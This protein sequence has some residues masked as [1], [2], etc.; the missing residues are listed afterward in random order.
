MATRAAAARP[1]QLRT[2]AWTGLDRTGKRVTGNVRS[3]D[4]DFVRAQLRAR[5]I[6]RVRVRKRSALLE[7]RRRIGP[8]DVAYF[9]RQMAT[10]LSSGVP[11]VTAFDIVGRGHENPAMMRLIMTL[12]ADVEGGSSLAEALAKHPAH[13]NELYVNL[14]GAGE[15][16]G[17]LDGLLARLATFLEKTEAIKRK[18]RSAL[19][20]PA[21]VVA[22]GIIVTAI[23]L[24][25]VIPVFEDLFVSF[26]ANLP[27]LTRAVMRLSEFTQQW[28]WLMGLVAIGAG[29]G[30]WQGY[31]R[32]VRFQH[33]VDR[34]SLRI[35]IIGEVLRKATVARFARTLSTMFAA[36]VP[37]VDA[38]ES[39]A[40]ASGNVVYREGILRM[41]DEV[42]AGGT[43]HHAMENTNLFAHMVVQMTSIGEEAG[44]L[45]AMLGKVADF[46]EDEVD[47]MV[48]RMTSLLEP[49]IMV[50]LGGLVGGLVIAMYLPIFKLASVF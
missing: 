35:P 30:T 24:L 5:G 33:A 23:L 49:L 48:E 21:A 25:F 18:V 20:Y 28:W 36:G 47:N 16:A 45:D 39:V 50:V 14:V 41:R 34:L 2:Y 11:M 1:E 10:M 19:F 44:S 29:I 26:G 37:L 17:I 27:A 38:M 9:T 3:P 42:A 12:K 32:S 6:Q 8:K 31:R 15:Q 46:Y 40:K 43:L 22:V 13:F 4:E 7:P